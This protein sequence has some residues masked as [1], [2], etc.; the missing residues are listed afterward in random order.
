MHLIG[1]YS[2][3]LDKERTNLKEYSLDYYSELCGFRQLDVYD[4]GILSSSYREVIEDGNKKEYAFNN[5]VAMNIMMTL[6]SSV[7]ECNSKS[8]Y[9]VA[10]P[11]GV[12]IRCTKT[13]GN[14][15]YVIDKY[16]RE[17]AGAE[18][19]SKE[20]SIYLTYTENNFNATDIQYTE[21]Q[22][23]EEFVEAINDIPV[24]SLSEISLEKDI[25]WLKDKKY[26]V[27]NDDETA[28]KLFSYF[29]TYDGI[30][31]YDT[32]TTGLHINMFSKI[33]SSYKKE[34][35][36][37]NRDKEDA[38]KIVADS[39]VGIIFCVEKDVSYYFPCANRKYKNLYEDRGSLVRQRLINNIKSDYTIGKYRDLDTDMARYWRDTPDDEVTSD[40]LVMERC[41]NILTTR[42]LVAHH[43]KFDWKVT[44][45]YDIDMNLKDDTQI[46]HQLMYKFRSTTAN[47][48]EP[49]NLKYLTFTEFGVD[50][51]GLEDFFAGYSEDE[52]GSVRGTVNGKRRKKKDLR[53]DFS[54]M[55]LIGSRAY[56][57]A[58]GDF[59]FQL[60][61]KYKQDL[62]TNHKEMEYIYNVEIIVACAVA[63]M[64]FYGHRIDEDKIESVKISNK[65]KLLDIEHRIRIEAGY[66]DELEN[67]LFDEIDR[68]QGMI[69]DGLV[70]D[71]ADTQEQLTELYN[72]ASE[73]INNSSNVLNL[74]SPK[75]VAELFFDKL[76]IPFN[77]EKISVGKKI[78]K[79]YTKQTNEDGSPKYPVINYYTDWK[80]IDTLL[81][82]FFE[83]LPQFMYPGGYIFTSYGQI[84]TATGRMSASKPNCQQ[85]PKDI[86]KI[87]IPRKNYVHLDADF[88]QIEYRTLVAMAKEDHLAELFKD[89]DSDYHTMMA[90]LMYGVPYSLVTPKMR[91]D[92]KS[93][94]FGI[95]YGMGFASLAILL[96]GS[97]GPAQIEEAKEKYELYFKDQPN[98]KR[99][100]ERVKEMAL[101]NKYTK[102]YWNRYRYYSFTGKDGR[103]SEAKKASA[104][105]QAGNAVIQGCL[106]GDTLIQTKDFGIV[107]IKDIVNRSL[108]VWDGDNWSHGDVLYSG[109]K[110]KCII[111]FSNGQEFICSPIHKFLVKSARGNERFVECKDLKSKN[112][113]NNPDRVVINRKYEASDYKHSCDRFSSGV[114]YNKMFEDA[115]VSMDYLFEDTDMLR[116]YMYNLISSKGVIAGDKILLDCLVDTNIKKALL[117]LGIKTG[118]V[119]G[120]L[121]MDASVIEDI[122]SGNLQSLGD[123]VY[124][125]SV[126]IT[127]EYIDMYDVCNTD[128]GYYVADGVITH[129]TAADIYKIAVAR[130][131]MWIR[132]NNLYGDVLV[133]NMV[134][135]EQLIEINCDTINVQ[136]AFRDIVDCMQFNVDGF[137]PLYVGAGISSDW[138][139]AK[140][141]M[142]EIHPDLAAQLS[143]EADNM[144]IR[145]EKSSSAKD[146][147]AYFNDRVYQFRVNKVKDY[148]LDSK[149]HNETLHPVI[150]GL[151]NLQ[152]TYGL[153]KEYSGNELTRQALKAFIERNNLDIDYTLFDIPLDEVVEDDEDEDDGYSDGDEGDDGFEDLDSNT[154]FQLIDESDK[155][156]GSTPQD[157]IKEF[158]VVLSQ[159]MHLCGIDMEVVPYKEKDNLIDYLCMHQV[160]DE[161][162]GKDNAL[163]LVF[164]RSSNTL[165]RTN[166]WVNGVDRA[167]MIKRFK[168]RVR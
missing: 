112:T 163:E 50:Q 12:V 37:Y 67:S 49:S 76:G 165:F 105:R 74:A 158:G 118:V 114:M 44:Y 53:V 144:P 86:T 113:S 95:P 145:V 66:S 2:I 162:I 152:F 47:S 5:R 160:S 8:A 143:I 58:D 124:V 77:G 31:A 36:E 25:T 61:M 137:P 43:G 156:F 78:L 122:K 10:F 134:H 20:E 23:E 15:T 135:D 68:L 107:K 128:G 129:N 60:C 55:D 64:E 72:K 97:R 130:T 73:A 115:T 140:G 94:N 167:E 90:S 102:T 24:R 29:D 63:Y 153:E 21:L 91:S 104:L 69:K 147:I 98:V 54:Y 164:L 141:K 48:G 46:M 126:E 166:V 149:N 79:S 136:R 81:S 57:P 38:D 34:L 71:N 3:Y 13:R 132:N 88:S 155:L 1:E 22:K 131:F 62:M 32:E 30:I 154:A 11:L 83:Q 84:S 87:V 100:F 45:C 119:D 96:T 157:L 159:S 121:A 108:L 18:I 99:F 7:K 125:E 93:F 148:L 111:H 52:S 70:E 17:L 117:F 80:K 75:Q 19:K 14:T 65:R 39:L 138:A 92:A 120:K 151:L 4:S 123:T 33:N 82:K 116:G 51:L 89:P 28:E 103:V 168:L 106:H 56:A 9:P 27:V 109:K 6:D 133:V 127:D 40:C 142:A 146:V 35:D 85:Y 26:Y 161:Q 150:G 110:R 41:R 101:V 59:T 16:D 42:H 139:D